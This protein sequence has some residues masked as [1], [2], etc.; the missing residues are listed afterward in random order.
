MKDKLSPDEKK[1]CKNCSHQRRDHKYNVQ[2]Q[3]NDLKCGYPKCT[4][5]QFIEWQ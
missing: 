5:I 1:L 4:C 3:N 2:E